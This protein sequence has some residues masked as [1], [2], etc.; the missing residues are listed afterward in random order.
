MT[1][2]T[3]WHNRFGGSDHRYLPPNGLPQRLLGGVAL[4]F[5][6][7]LCSWTVC[8]FANNDAYQTHAVRGDRS[9][10]A[11]TFADRFARANSLGAAAAPFDVRFS[12]ESGFANDELRR[13]DGDLTARAL[14]S[15]RFS[16]ANQTTPVTPLPPTRDRANRS[17]GLTVLRL[18]STHSAALRD[19]GQSK[20]TSSETPENKPTVLQ[21]ILQK[22][23]G[24]PVPVK[25]AYAASDD[26]GLSGGQS[27][28]AGRYDRWTAVYDISAHTVY[29]PNG[30]RLEAHSGL[31]SWLD[32]PRYPDEKMRGVTPPNIYGLE[33][34]ESSFHG[35]RA[36]RLIPEDEEKVF[37]RRGLLAHSYMLGPNGDSNGCVSIKNYDAFLQAYLD[38]DI[39]RLAVVTRLE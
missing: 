34:R 26:T 11:V 1:F 21:S 8:V 12:L 4:A 24:K 9:G 29:M 22:L 7:T 23:F 6:A 18:G 33:L 2:G 30:N 17:A 32:D 25:L 14:F 31:G 36:L 3:E 19:G 27:I 20:Q 35:V 15:D 28:A 38:H 16:A 5:V 39:K 13:S 10:A 37:G